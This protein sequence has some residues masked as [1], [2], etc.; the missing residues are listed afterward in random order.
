[1]GLGDL[2]KLFSTQDFTDKYYF[3]MSIFSDGSVPEKTD[4]IMQAG[5]AI[6][7]PLVWFRRE[8]GHER[9][10]GNYEAANPVK[11]GHEL[12]MVPQERKIVVAKT[13]DLNTGFLDD[14]LRKGEHFD[15]IVNFA[16]RSATGD[17]RFRESISLKRAKI[18]RII[19]QQILDN[20]FWEVLGISFRHSSESFKD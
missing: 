9:I 13:P 2:V 16:V 14:L 15:A 1:M 20:K 11:L 10:F 17:E 8:L 19:R 4:P 3:W 7:F 12:S 18:K 6:G 5:G